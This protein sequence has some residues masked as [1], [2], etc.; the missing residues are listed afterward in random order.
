MDRS[1]GIFRRDTTLNQLKTMKSSSPEESAHD[2]LLVE[3]AVRAAIE[4][5]KGRW[6]PSILFLL[7]DE[8]KRFSE[9]QAALG[10]V[11]AQALTAQLKQLEGDGIISR[12]VF[13]DVPVRVEYRITEFGATL[14][15]VMDQLDEW[16]NAFLKRASES[17]S[18]K[19]V[20]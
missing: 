20:P 19:N 15:T 9:L 5:I 6:K 14:S 10:T 7:K 3:C 18:Q 12:E 4:V 8:P 13:A 2:P 17:A 16:G 1:V 11:S